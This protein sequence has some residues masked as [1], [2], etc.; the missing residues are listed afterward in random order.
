MNKV[1][2]ITIK[3]RAVG[4]DLWGKEYTGQVRTWS[5]EV[6]HKS[7]RQAKALGRAAFEKSGNKYVPPILSVRAAFVREY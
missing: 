5:V 2:N 7:E 1:W 6:D 3:Y 4:I